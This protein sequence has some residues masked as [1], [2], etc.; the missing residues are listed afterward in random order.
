VILCADPLELDALGL[1]VDKFEEILRSSSDLT[2]SSIGIKRA[3]NQL[4]E[5]VR[6][7]SLDVLHDIIVTKIMSKDVLDVSLSIHKSQIILSCRSDRW[8][9]KK[10]ATTDAKINILY[11]FALVYGDPHNRDMYRQLNEIFLLL[12]CKIFDLVKSLDKKIK[13]ELKLRDREAQEDRPKT[14][15]SSIPGAK[16]LADEM[17]LVVDIATGDK[18]VLGKSTNMLVPVHA[19]II[20]D[21]WANSKGKAHRTYAR[22]KFDPAN[23]HNPGAPLDLVKIQTGEDFHSEVP[24]INL[25]EQ[26]SWRFLQ[27]EWGG[28]PPEL[29]EKFICHLFPDP[30]P[31]EYVLDWMANGVFSRNQTYLVLVGNPGT[32]KTIFG[33]LMCS[34]VGDQY[35]RKAP[36]SITQ[37]DNR[38]NASL[39][40][41]CFLYIDERNLWK[42]KEQLKEYINNRV[43]LESKGVDA[44]DAEEIHASFLITSNSTKHL[45]L[46]CKDRR[47]SVPEISS[48]YLRDTMS[49]ADIEDFIELFRS[50]VRWKAQLGHYLKRRFE[51]LQ[52]NFTH[53]PYKN[54]AYYKLVLETMPEWLKLLTVFCSKSDDDH[55]AGYPRS[56]F[57]KIFKDSWGDGE[58]SGSKKFNRHHQM[59]GNPTVIQTSRDATYWGHQIYEAR[60]IK[61]AEYRTELRIFPQLHKYIEEIELV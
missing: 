31:R 12:T 26:P 11:Q 34:L 53:L 23:P 18:K 59:P 39:R 30:E 4:P 1:V 61:I 20:E 35:A 56:H 5:D 19:A 8:V 37:P 36:Q 54:S 28:D 57:S 7:E 2:G 22:F 58:G 41:C 16:F 24:V 45:K 17:E 13:A 10:N 27:D 50:D 33:D 6:A 38:F 49:Q 60:E 47:F 21:C 3:F 51:V 40:H 9:F 32:G 29:F 48:K 14:T 43:T 25:Y 15:V 46:E 52:K 42:V 55:E 44:I